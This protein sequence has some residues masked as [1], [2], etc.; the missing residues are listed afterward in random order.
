MALFVHGPLTSSISGSVGGNTFSRNGAGSTIRS[1][2]KPVDPR[3]TKQHAQRA[4]FSYVS[5]LWRT[6]DPVTQQ[7]WRDAAPSWL[8]VNKVGQS[9]AL[10]GFGLFSM[11]NQNLFQILENSITS[12]PSIDSPASYTFTSLVADNSAQTLIASINFSGSGDYFI[13]F[14]GTTMLSPGIAY[15]T[16]Q[17]KYLGFMG[18][19]AGNVYDISS[20][21]IATYGVIGNVGQAIWVTARVINKSTGQAFDFVRAQSIIA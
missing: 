5:R 14:Y 1:R 21:Y 18:W 11:L 20:L 12:P 16:S 13:Q 19:D 10:A 17:Y 4:S 6:L 9:F 8:R 15:L 2:T 7:L 3:S